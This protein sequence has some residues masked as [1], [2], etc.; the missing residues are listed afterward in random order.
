MAYTYLNA[1]LV[2]ASP[3]HPPIGVVRRDG[4]VWRYFMFTASTRSTEV[5]ATR[6][7]AARAL[8]RASGTT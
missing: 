3:S 7:A 6:E 8:H 5:F 4:H 1:Y 2:A